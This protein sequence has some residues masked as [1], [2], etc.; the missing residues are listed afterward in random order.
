MTTPTEIYEQGLDQETQGFYRQAT[1]ATSLTEEIRLVRARL[2]SAL[3]AN[4]EDLIE[5]RLGILMKLLELQQRIGR[6]SDAHEE[7]LR[8]LRSEKLRQYQEEPALP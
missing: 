1:A 8:A 2:T 4:D 3:K 7:V 6:P 5:R